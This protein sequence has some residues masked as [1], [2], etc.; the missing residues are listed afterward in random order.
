LV[1]RLVTQIIYEATYLIN[2][3]I[4]VVTV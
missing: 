4:K 2:T 1:G 3:K